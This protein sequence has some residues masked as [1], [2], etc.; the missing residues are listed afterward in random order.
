MTLGGTGS[1]KSQSW[2]GLG[3]MPIYDLIKTKNYKAHFYIFLLEDS[4]T[5]FE[6]RLFSACLYRVSGLSIDPMS[7]M[8]LREKLI[9]KEALAYFKK[10]DDMVEDIL[11][12]CTVYDTKYSA[13]SV[14]DT[15]LKESAKHGTHVYE[16]TKIQVGTAI[17]TV[18]EYKGYTTT[19]DTHRIV[20]L[21]NL[22]N[23]EDEW[24]AKFNKALDTRA[25]I[26]LWTRDYARLH[27]VKFW[28]WTV[29]NIM[30]A[31]MESEKKEF[32]KFGGNSIVEK[33]LPSLS[34]LGDNKVCARDHHLIIGI[35]SPARHGIPELT[36]H[37]I[38]RL[39]DNYRALSVLKSNMTVPN[40]LIPMWFNGACSTYADL[41]YP[42]SDKEYLKYCVNGN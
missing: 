1:G 27:V 7:L 28:G 29:W 18:N 12:Y 22:N 8:S 15:L 19:D 36:G 30:Q 38:G 4:V 20:F 24:N 41:P 40:F 11:N 5:M 2:L 26:S 35:F 14:Y 31:A 25:A 16:P 3:L 32:N 33:L 23:F 6:D 17:K 34:D 39:G 9:S 10:A 21:D 37:D 13:T 42:M